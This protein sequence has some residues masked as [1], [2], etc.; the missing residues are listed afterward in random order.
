[1]V[2]RW[3]WSAQPI[4]E[5]LWDLRRHQAISRQASPVFGLQCLGKSWGVEKHSSQMY[6][7]FCLVW[8]WPFNLTRFVSKKCKSFQT[9]FFFISW[10]SFPK[11]IILMKKGTIFSAELL[12]MA[13]IFVQIVIIHDF[14]LERVH[15]LINC[16]QTVQRLCNNRRPPRGITL[17]L[18]PCFASWTATLNR[19]T[20]GQK[21]NRER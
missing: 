1:M 20:I 3:R 18:P 21:D 9:I 17:A 4:Q 16:F 2:Y 19:D 5:L 15:D 8:W 11:K 6:V 12:N 10:C 14:T 13:P 7:A